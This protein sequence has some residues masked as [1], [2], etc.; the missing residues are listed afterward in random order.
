MC[1]ALKFS[2]Q[3]Q[4]DFLK[5]RSRILKVLEE[6]QAVFS[7]ASLV[8]CVGNFM[9]CFSNLGELL[10]YSPKSVALT[11][12]EVVFIF[13]STVMSLL[14][15][16]YT[17]GQVPLEMNTSSRMSRK[18]CEKRAFL[19]I[20]EESASLERLLL[21]EETFLLS[22]YEMIYFTRNG[23]LTI[24]GTILTYGLLVVSVDL[25]NEN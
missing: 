3:K 2:T 23:I 25:K 14:S 15:I 8:I 11:I 22:G 13:A 21:H 7:K 16:F 9:T 20:V 1:P 5:Q 10:F 19:G 18:L 24:L 17:A 12:I 4:I 6:I